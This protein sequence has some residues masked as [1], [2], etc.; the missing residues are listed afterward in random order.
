M[1]YIVITLYKVIWVTLE[2][3]FDKKYFH[4]IHPTYIISKP[5]QFDQSG[6]LF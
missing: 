1:I 4:R 5:K 6:L 3:A 2:N